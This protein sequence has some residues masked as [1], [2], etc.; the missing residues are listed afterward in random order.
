[1]TPVFVAPPKMAFTVSGA[2]LNSTY[3]LTT[4]DIDVQGEQDAYAPPARKV[5]KFFC[6]SFLSY[7]GLYI[8]PAHARS[9]VI[10]IE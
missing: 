5:H 4:S 2:T 9:Y 1:M 8:E 10:L 3:S 6:T 7:L